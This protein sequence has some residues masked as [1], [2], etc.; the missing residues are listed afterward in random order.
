MT[1]LY[2]ILFSSTKMY[3]FFIIEFLKVQL[4]VLNGRQASHKYGKMV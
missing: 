4:K 3:I 1:N 2:Y